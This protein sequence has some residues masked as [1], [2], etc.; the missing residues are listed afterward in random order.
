MPS[1]D[2]WAP[3]HADVVVIGG[4]ISGLSAAWRLV[5]REPSLHVVVLDA[6]SQVGGKLATARV[7]GCDVDAGAE[8]LLARR[9]EGL[10]L[11]DELYRAGVGRGRK[12]PVTPATSAAHVWTGSGLVALPTHTVM[13]F[14]S[15]R[16]DLGSVGLPEQ[17]Q[18][19]PAHLA[20]ARH[21]DVSVAALARAGWPQ[22]V[23]DQLVDPLVGGVYAGRADALS[24][25]SV[26]PTLMAQV[27]AGHDLLAAADA[28]V[29][30][31]DARAGDPVFVGYDGGLGR[32][33]ADLSAV[34]RDSGVHVLSGVIAHRLV[35][36]AGAWEVSSG[37]VHQPWTIRAEAVVVAT[38]ATAS[39]RLVHDHA[40]TAA[41][42]LRGVD[43]AS[44]AVVTLAL[45][46][47]AMPEL[48]GSGVLVPS[49]AG[50][51]I[52]AAT[53][54][55]AKWAW[56]DAL[57][58]DLVFVRASFGRAGETASVQVADAA[59]VARAH[60]DLG[61]ML[62][63]LPDA[64]D[65]GVHRW[66][67]ALPQYAVGHHSLMQTLHDDIAQVAGL[68]VAGATYAGVGIPS[69]IATAQRAADAILDHVTG[70]RTRRERMQG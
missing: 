1:A 51:E 26:V 49:G 24:A 29:A 45:P 59:L 53:F 41:A 34:L 67:G 35:R 42:V 44:V 64:V 2:I 31:S 60:A 33:A 3:A 36:A 57:D 21:G 18:V 69:C 37:P 47:A 55:S 61:T 32:L 43:C 4:G 11:I 20:A 16:T 17:S 39:S 25:E 5:T 66:G 63:A 52:K 10:R 54:S 40:P 62:G 13:G 19:S 27:R 48:D 58:P 38:P 14:P 56:V 9:P 6:G 65:A 8:S 12:V 50:L 30:Q 28:L 7:A 68:E 15:S 23:V 22:A 70:S 46:R